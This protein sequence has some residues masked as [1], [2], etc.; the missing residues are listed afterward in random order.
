MKL[1]LRQAGLTLPELMVAI[2]L[3]TIV[4]SAL[5]AMYLSTSRNFSQNERYALM[6]ENGRYALKVLADDLIMADFW[7][8]MTATDAS[9]TTL[10]PTGNCGTGTPGGGDGIDLFNGDTALLY[11][12][13]HVGGTAQLPAAWP[14]TEITAVQRVNTPILAV[15]RVQGVQLSSAPVNNTVRLRTNGVA[16][17]FIDDTS[18]PPAP[19]G[20]F[21]WLYMPRI[22]FIRDFLDTVGDGI[23]SLCRMELVGN[24]LSMGQVTNFPD[25]TADSINCLAEGIED[26]H[27]QFGIDTDSDGIAN[28]YLSSPTL[29]EL[30]GAVAARIYVLARALEPDPFYTDTKNFALGDV[31]LAQAD[32]GGTNFYRRVFST[33][34]MLRNSVN[35]NLLNN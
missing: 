5:L 23:P 3:S 28:Q 6:Q 25:G 17:S 16:G 1:K 2:L 31:N 33:T 27:I 9:T 29:V 35:L 18:W 20:F 12:N 24:P 10:A 7:G 11:N 15:K 34:V 32:L 4:T 22:Y 13:K 30:E 8:R 19:A 14:C 26:F 21:D